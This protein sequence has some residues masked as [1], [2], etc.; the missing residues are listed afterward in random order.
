V[1]QLTSRIRGLLEEELPYVW[2]GGEISNLGRPTSG[3][4]YFTLKDD[5]SQIRT[6]LWRSVRAR[7]KFELS[8]GM[9]VII[10]GRCSIYEGRSEYQLVVDQLVPKGLGAL[11]LA[12]RQLRERLEKEG[13]FAQHHKKSLPR[14]PRR[15][16][17]MTSP[18]GAAVRD[19][20]QVIAR[21]WK[22]IDVLIW[23]VRVQG[24]GAAQEIAAAIAQ[25]N[26][27][28]DIDVMVVGRGGGSLEDL[29]AFNE[30]VVARAIFASQIPIISAVGH[31]VDWTIADYVADLRAP[32]P[33]AA[34][35]LSV[36]NESE[37]RQYLDQSATRLAR[38][39]QGRLQTARLCFEQLAGRRPFRVPLDGVLRR[40]QRCD[41]LGGRLD[42]A[43]WNRLRDGEHRMARLAGLIQGLSPLNVLARGYS[44][45]TRVD[46]H[47]VLRSA[48]QVACG[49]QI[50]TRLESGSIA[51][52]VEQKFIDTAR[53]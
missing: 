8:D 11:E 29:W 34:A 45:T 46:G 5:R 41:D 12:F 33:S 18:T 17:L 2:V 35:E 32:T 20:L 27:L 49:E 19:M 25:A 37:M 40:Q 4:I 24:E 39:L 53:H 36:P 50:L 52:R 44:L 7:M 10:Q 47:T 3:H 26:R 23:P 28:C 6:V 13:L 16:V 14:F 1:S 42:R 21:R 22:A 48:E 38:A 15:V 9:Q 30:E 31:E 43:V 51:S